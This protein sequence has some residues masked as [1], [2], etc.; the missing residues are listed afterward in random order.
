MNSIFGNEAIVFYRNAVVIVS[1][2]SGAFLF[3]GSPDELIFLLICYRN[4]DLDEI[5]F[6]VREEPLTQVN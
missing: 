5:V 3:N 4:L 6:R 2:E 1:S